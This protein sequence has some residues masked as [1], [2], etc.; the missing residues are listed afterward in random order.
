MLDH[1]AVDTLELP[2]LR[3][4]FISN[5]D[6]MSLWVE[7]DRHTHGV[8]G[9]DVVDHLTAACVRSLRK[10]NLTADNVA[11]TRAEMWKAQQRSS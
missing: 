2:K 10:V 6:L 9:D 7:I 8:L 4:P 11:K 5:D 1:R 3:P